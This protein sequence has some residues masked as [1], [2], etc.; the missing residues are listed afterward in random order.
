M[1]IVIGL[2]ILI[3]TIT[4]MI[5][6]YDS[7]VLLLC[8]GLL[9]AVLGGNPVAGLKGYTAGLAST[10]VMNAIISAAAFAAVSQVS[11]C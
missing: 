7:K 3:V 11:G 8:G 1:N 5:K 4:L 10:S 2:V 9:M 6:K